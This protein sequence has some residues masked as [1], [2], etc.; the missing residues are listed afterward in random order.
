MGYALHAI[1]TEI[2]GEKEDL[3]QGTGPVPARPE[4]TDEE[5]QQLEQ[6]K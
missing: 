1:G 5:R 3:E 6:S 4:L 2:D